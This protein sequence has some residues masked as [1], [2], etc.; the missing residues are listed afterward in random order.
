MG[1]AARVADLSSS[2][3]LSRLRSDAL[4]GYTLAGRWFIP[5][6]E[7]RRAMTSRAAAA[8]ADDAAAAA[9]RELTAHLPRT[10][11]ADTLAAFFGVRRGVLGE[12]LDIPRRALLTQPDRLTTVG[13]LGATLLRARNASR[14]FPAVAAAD[15][16]RAA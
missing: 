11:D 16:A 1:A 8:P 9:V 12:M 3:L 2:T 13:V 5:E 10:L 4:P 14:Y 7:F 6:S 15:A